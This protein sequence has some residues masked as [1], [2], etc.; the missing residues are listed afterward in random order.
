MNR[1]FTDFDAIRKGIEQA[2]IEAQKFIRDHICT[3]E[4]VTAE[5]VAA[6]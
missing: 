5:A 1:N 6:E 4:P 3:G 2:N